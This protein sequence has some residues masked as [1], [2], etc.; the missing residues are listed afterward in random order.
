M[1]GW[2][3]LCVKDRKSM[4]PLIR[5]SLRPLLFLTFCC[6][7]EAQQAR[8]ELNGL[9]TQ[10]VNAVDRQVAPLREKYLS[11]LRVLK[12]K[13]TKAGDLESAILVDKELKSETGNLD[14][15]GTR[16]PGNESELR[17]FLMKNGWINLADPKVKYEFKDDGK[18]F[19]GN[20]FIGYYQATGRRKLI[21]YWGGAIGK[22]P[23]ECV[24][25]EDCLA[26]SEM[27]GYRNVWT[28]AR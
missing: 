18:M 9:R 20:R 1:D 23:I 17:D 25:S 26:I 13:Y 19:D 3:C 21:M 4:Y 28:R 14:G 6:A 16:L 27:S 5:Q 11:G 22:G 12:E 15:P 7:A 24:M 10:Y 2:G 8:V